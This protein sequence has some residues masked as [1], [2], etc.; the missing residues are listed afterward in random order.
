M[1]HPASLTLTA[2]LLCIAPGTACLGAD[3]AAPAAQTTQPAGSKSGAPPGE[4]WPDNPFERMAQATAQELQTNALFDGMEFEIFVAKPF[5]ILMTREPGSDPART[6]ERKP[7]IEGLARGIWHN[8]LKIRADWQLSSTR[9]DT[10]ENP[11]PFVW[12]AFHSKDAYDVTLQLS[13]VFEQG[14]GGNEPVRT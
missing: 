2:L 14:S 4:A 5:V 6:A 10:L 1:K 7:R 13:E 9:K 11:E 8:W 12:V 3:S